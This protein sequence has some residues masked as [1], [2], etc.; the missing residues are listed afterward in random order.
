MVPK[1]PS[2]QSFF[3]SFS[4]VRLEEREA[5][6]RGSKSDAIA[7]R[8]KLQIIRDKENT[9]NMS[10]RDK[11][12][13]F[14]LKVLSEKIIVLKNVGGQRNRKKLGKKFMILMYFKDR[15]SVYTA[16]KNTQQ[17]GKIMN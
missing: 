9:K 13:I 12:I 2:L 16:Q 1:W 6:V 17:G 7:L 8:S 15:Y 5:A 14:R 10:R 11:C 3:P 4:S